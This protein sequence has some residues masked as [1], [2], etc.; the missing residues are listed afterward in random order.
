MIFVCKAI[1]SNY[2]YLAFVTNN[3]FIN[4]AQNAL[5][6][7]LVTDLEQCVYGLATCKNL[8]T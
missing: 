1:T 3:F 5:S 2:S 8:I 6:L 7:T 4:Y